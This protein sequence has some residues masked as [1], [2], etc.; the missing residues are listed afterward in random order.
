MGL[1]FNGTTQCLTIA[2]SPVTAAPVTMSCWFNAPVLA[3]QYYLLTLSSTTA[4]DHS[5]FGIFGQ[6]TGVFVEVSNSSASTDVS[7][8]ST[9][10][11]STNTTFHICCVNVSP[12]SHTIYVNGGTPATGV[13]SSV[14]NPATLNSTV[15]AG[16]HDGSSTVINFFNANMFFPAVWNIDLS[17]A[18]VL[19]LSK[20]ISPRKIQPSHLVRYARLTGHAATT[21]PDMINSVG[22]TVV[23]A[24]TES[25]NVRIYFP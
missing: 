19:S 20:G 24:P 11:V 16:L 8:G 4:S 21:E 25:A 15:L 10:P 17:A 7:T 9:V 13:T 14:P 18:D 5:L 6:T 23:A 22:W 2:S 12:T 1:L 3:A